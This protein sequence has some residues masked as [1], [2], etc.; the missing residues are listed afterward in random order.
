MNLKWVSSKS[1]SWFLEIIWNFLWWSFWLSKRRF[2]E[3]IHGILNTWLG[4]TT[5]SFIWLWDGWNLCTFEFFPSPFNFWIY[6][7][8]MLKI[9][10]HVLISCIPKKYWFDKLNEFKMNNNFSLNYNLWYFLWI[11]ILISRYSIHEI[12]LWIKIFCLIDLLRF[13]FDYLWGGFS[14]RNHVFWYS[15]V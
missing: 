12:L 1:W 7:C 8:Y 4:F 14:K 13:S 15:H 2:V 9:W 3:M 11:V 6:A 5:W 10:S